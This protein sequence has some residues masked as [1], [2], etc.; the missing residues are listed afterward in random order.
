[1]KVTEA[2][3]HER[4]KYF[5]LHQTK[6][7]YFNGSHGMPYLP[8]ISSLSWFNERTRLLDAGCGGNHFVKE[9]RAMGAPHLYAQGLDF[10]HPDADVRTYLHGTSLEDSSF[11]IITSFDVLEH[12]LPEDVPT[13]LD[14]LD[15]ISADRCLWVHK[16]S[17]RPSRFTVNGENLHPTVRNSAWWQEQLC[18]TFIPTW[19]HLDD[20]GTFI[21]FRED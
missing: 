10:A 7:S 20:R 21:M 6:P 16:I 12:I 9:L 11:D 4:S 1:M 18:K 8:W 5:H 13:V 3:A 15:R 2:Q 19:W 17:T 14:E